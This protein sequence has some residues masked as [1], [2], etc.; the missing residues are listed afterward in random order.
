M[1]APVAK[2]ITDLPTELGAIRS[3]GGRI[4]GKGGVIVNLPIDFARGG[5]QSGGINHNR[6]GV[7][8]D[9][10]ENRFFIPR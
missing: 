4:L 10:S 2:T 3:C 9:D 1:C 8:G 7:K 6:E 5:G